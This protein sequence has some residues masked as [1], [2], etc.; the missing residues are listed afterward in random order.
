[1]S[2]WS[3]QIATWMEAQTSCG[4]LNARA[5]GGVPFLS[6]KE[7]VLCLIYLAVVGQAQGAVLVQH[8][9]QF[10]GGDWAVVEPAADQESSQFPDRDDFVGTAGMAHQRFGGQGELLILLVDGTFVATFVRL[11]AEPV[12][13]FHG[14]FDQ[15]QNIVLALSSLRVDPLGEGETQSQRPLV[16]FDRSLGVKGLPPHQL[17]HDLAKFGLLPLKE[18]GKKDCMFKLI[19]QQ[20]AAAALG[21]GE[22]VAEAA[23]LEQMGEPADL[24][25][26]D[27][28]GLVQFTHG[29]VDG[30][31][32]AFAERTLTLHLGEQIVDRKRMRRAAQRLGDTNCVARVKF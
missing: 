19:Q 5:M 16:A 20:K 15:N 12:V 29:P 24:A 23:A 32:G 13:A 18:L 30:I 8:A 11:Q 21:C 26:S 25:G 6:P 3:I 31:A 28:D 1:M 27:W 2:T 22:R 10:I 17:D 14:I 9:V 7:C 4:T